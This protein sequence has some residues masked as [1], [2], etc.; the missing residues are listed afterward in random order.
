M[1]NRVNAAAPDFPPAAR[2]ALIP[3]ERF[4]FSFLTGGGGIEEKEWP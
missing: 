4:S 1:Q 3:A 2:S